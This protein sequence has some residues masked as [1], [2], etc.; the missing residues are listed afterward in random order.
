MWLDTFRALEQDRNT[1]GSVLLRNRLPLVTSAERLSTS[2]I[3][4][5]SAVLA[6]Y[7]PRDIG[8][9]EKRRLIFLLPNATQSLGRFLAVSLLLADFVQRNASGEGPLLK[10]DLLLVTQQI[11]DCVQ[12][13]RDLALRSGSEKLA[14]AKFWP[15]E[16]L[17]QYSAP[18]DG[19]PRAFVANPGW[20]SILGNRQTFGSVVIDVSH[21]RTA[22]HLESLLKQPSV[23]SSPVQILVVP[24]WEQERIGALQEEGRASDLLWAWDPASVRALEQI[25]APAVTLSFKESHDRLR[26]LCD[27]Q[28]VDGM[29]AE[30]HQ[31]LVG[32]MKAGSGRV[33]AEVLHAWA[34]YHKL[35]QLAVPLVSLEEERRKTYQTL[36]IR[37]RIQILDEI[38]PNARGHLSSYLDARWPR[39]TSVLSQL[40]EALLLRREPAK[41]YTLASII[42][43]HLTTGKEL[44]AL[45]IVVPTAHEANMLAALLGELVD[46]WSNALQSGLVSL[47]T[48]KEEPR[49]IAEGL[50]QATVLLGFR[51]SETRY[52]DVYP[53]VPVHVVVYPYETEIDDGIQQRTHASIEELQNNGQRVV[54]LQGLNLPVVT[55]SNQAQNGSGDT[56][57]KSKRPPIRQ[58]FEVHSSSVK[59]RRFS[60]DDAVEPLSIEKLAGQ[61]WSDEL[62]VAGTIDEQRTSA[63]RAVEY[64]DITDTTGQR[65]H[66]PATRVMDVF[67]PATE[68]KE[69]ISVEELM[70]GMLIVILVDDP[71]EDLFQRLL[72]AIRE[73][74]DLRASIALDLWD[75]AKR[76]A[77]TKHGGSRAALHAA[78]LKNGLSVDYP[79]LVGWYRVGEAEIL[80]PLRFEDFELLGR[81]SGIYSDAALLGATFACIQQER[82]VRRTSGRQLS[83]LLFHLAAGQHYHLALKSAEALGTA[84]EQVAAAV[85]IREVE[86]VVRVGGLAESCT[87]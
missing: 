74:R 38:P 65:L 18:T 66:Y 13:L 17:S 48:V 75:R 81:A 83:Q 30:L 49:L 56:A 11:R 6:S 53:G 77:L 32:A 44:E 9:G 8:Q 46:G 76:A 25:I 28:E 22:D 63:H 51:T 14:I 85:S 34:V 4:R 58:R 15:I 2:I 21:P 27:D 43:E 70:P 54:V 84:L 71:Y 86:S 50:P 35:R 40:Y 72:E 73:Q 5:A 61:S 68:Q 12:L 31:I 57:P 41:F 45:R 37:E 82:V 26:W 20:A 80:A 36:T 67:R 47:T 33:P 29:L 39:V 10:G 59:L 3:E 55:S 1:L 79:A 42:E 23:A 69:R 7:L 62:T 52:L 64:F 87:A 78:L 24:P 16:V 19:K 60:T